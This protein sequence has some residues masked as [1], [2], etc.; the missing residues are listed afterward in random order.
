[1]PYLFFWNEARLQLDKPY[2]PEARDKPITQRL[3][4]H[5]KHWIKIGL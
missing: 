4:V 5:E 1:M 2:N 3:N